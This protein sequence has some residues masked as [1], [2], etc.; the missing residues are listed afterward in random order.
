MFTGEKK[1]FAI[2][3]LGCTSIL[4]VKYSTFF[5]LKYNFLQKLQFPS[6]ENYWYIMLL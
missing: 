2:F 5:R 6:Y 4:S 1:A 3:I